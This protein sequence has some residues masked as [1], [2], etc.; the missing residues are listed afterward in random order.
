M[1]P[2]EP[3]GYLLSAFILSVPSFS[4]QILCST[5]YSLL[6]FSSFGF[7]VSSDEFSDSV[8]LDSLYPPENGGSVLFQGT[9]DRFHLDILLVELPR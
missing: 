3:V 4:N 2:L 5:I 7:F 6:P 9:C 8:E 1:D